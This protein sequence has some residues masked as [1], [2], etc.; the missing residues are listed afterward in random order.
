MTDMARKDY[1][2][3]INVICIWPGIKLWMWDNDVNMIKFAELVGV[4][5]HTISA[6]FR[7]LTDMRMYTVRRILEVTGLTFEQAFG[8]QL[9]PEEARRKCELQ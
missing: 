7:G 5:V 2:G 1:K 4:H 3:F 8:K 6:N 9:T